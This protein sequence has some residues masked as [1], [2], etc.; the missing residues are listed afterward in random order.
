ME[1]AAEIARKGAIAMTFRVERRW[2]MNFAAAV[3]ES[4]PCYYGDDELSLTVHPMYQAQLEWRTR[5]K[6]MAVST[7]PRKLR[8]RAVHSGQYLKI[9]RLLRVGETITMQ[10]AVVGAEPGRSGARITTRFDTFDRSGTPISTAVASV[11]YL[12]VDLIGEPVK[13]PTMPSATIRKGT[14]ANQGRRDTLQLTRGAAHTYG[15]CARIWNPIHSDE[16]TARRAG[17]RGTVMHGSALL[18]MTLS[19]VIN[20]EGNGDPSATASIAARF[21]S[22]VPLPHQPV[23]RILARAR[24]ASEGQLDFWLIREDGVVATEGS[25]LLHVSV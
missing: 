8:E 18:A 3:G 2:A 11:T 6:L 14:P 16:V 20:H 24:Q 4:A 1:L 25:C 7:L 21:R 17:L 12:G 19:N 13:P 5:K 9:E 15:E 22:P 23:L 10:A